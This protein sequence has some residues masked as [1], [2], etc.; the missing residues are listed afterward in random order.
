M[1]YYYVHTISYY[2]NNN[3]IGRLTSGG[4]STHFQC[5]IAMGY[6]SPK[7][8]NAGQKIQVK[9]LNKLWDAKIVDDSP[10]DPKN[11]KIKQDG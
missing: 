8:A 6:V 2:V 7:Y 9:M 1:H 5:S 11:G 4:Y 3:R 10:Y